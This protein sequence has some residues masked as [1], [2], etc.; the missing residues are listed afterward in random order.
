MNLKLGVYVRMT[1]DLKALQEISD[2]LPCILG[3]QRANVLIL[4]PRPGVNVCSD[5]GDNEFYL[6]IND[7]AL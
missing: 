2:E 1:Q 5:H 3:Y 7:V 6:L 4:D